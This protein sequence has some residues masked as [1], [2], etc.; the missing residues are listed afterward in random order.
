M[1]NDRMNALW[2]RAHVPVSVALA[3]VCGSAGACD[4]TDPPETDSG[5]MREDSSG[6]EL[7]HNL[8]MPAETLRVRTPTLRIGLVDGPAEYVFQDIRDISRLR[9]GAV[10]VLDRGGRVALFDNTGQ[11]VRDLGGRGEGP[12]EYVQ[13]L[14]VF[15]FG[16]TIAVR[17]PALRRITFYEPSGEVLEV[18]RFE[19]GSAARPV[20]RI[21]GGWVAELES[22]QLTDPAPA[23]GV[24]VRL[25]GGE[26][27]TDTLMGPYP[28]PEFGWQVV[29]EDRG[30]MVNPPVFSIWPPWATNDSSLA[31]SPG[32]EPRIEH[33]LTSGELLRVV[34]WPEE[35]RPPAD[36]DRERYFESWMHQFEPPEDVARQ[37]R[38]EADFAERIP[39]VTRLVAD[40]RGQVWA[41]GFDPTNWLRDSV[42]S[43]WLVFGGDGRLRRAVAF[44]AGFEL[45]EVRNGAALGVRQTELGIHLVEQYDV[46]ATR[47]KT[48][49]ADR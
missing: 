33:R 4:R 25:N 44:P 22:G 48:A 11:W 43:S 21:A 27:S 19:A 35:P 16:D 29:S 37:H 18:R 40:D 17:D 46:D 28:V 45:V 42:G 12:G 49:P 23:R 39:L 9:T 30:H 8:A 15:V 7:V 5:L 26:V 2:H 32:T 24:L 41:G 36:A 6:V 1:Q 38:G 13:P 20:G 47:P 10:V 3:L 31:W 34:T 14:Q